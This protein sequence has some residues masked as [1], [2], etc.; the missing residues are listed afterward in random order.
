MEKSYSANTIIVAT[1][2]EGNVSSPLTFPKMG[3]GS[4]PGLSKTHNAIARVKTPFIEVF[5]YC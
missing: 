5:L 3:L 4:P 1:H 2:F